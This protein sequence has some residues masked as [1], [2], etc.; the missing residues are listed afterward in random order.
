MNLSEMTDEKL[1][2]LYKSGESAAF[3]EL[4]FR[5]K[6]VIV[7]ASRSFYLSGGDKDD[8]LQEGFLGLLKAVD[9]Y[10]GKSS[11]KSYVYLCIRSKMIT[12]IK[13]SLNG[14]NRAMCGYVSLYGQSTE[15]SRL[16][17]TDPEEKIIN[18]EN[19]REFMDKVRSKLSKFEIVVLNYYL[20]GL[21][22]TEI[23]TKLGKDP[24]CIDNALQRIK[25]K[26][27]QI[28]D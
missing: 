22:Y 2:E 15:L 7:A 11:F 4:Y 3:D 14:K 23:S 13:K 28:T 27:S 1:V 24:K 8:L 21:T 18:D 19:A 20:D 12:A 16:F 26:I 9:T 17:G 25:R 5:Y 6:Y 10:N